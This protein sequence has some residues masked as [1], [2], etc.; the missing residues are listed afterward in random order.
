[1]NGYLYSRRFTG[2]FLRRSRLSRLA[3]F[4][5]LF[6][7]ALWMTAASTAFAQV[8]TCNSLT[9]YGA[10]AASG[11]CKSLSPTSQTHWVCELAAG[12]PDIHLTF[13]AATALHLTVRIPGTSGP[14][15]EGNSYLAGTF[16][17]K[18]SIQAGQPATICNVKVQ[19]WVTR[20]NAVAPIPPQG[21]QCK[22]GF[23]E[24]ERLGRI[25]ASV[26]NGYQQKCTDNRCQ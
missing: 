12:N 6:T 26:S 22:A 11:L 25:T 17:G 24:A 8:N 2:S 10:A 14:T 16:P 15:C 5:T 21:A 9:L 20:L 3:R 4:G 23:Q 13:N 1:M 18:F 19:D 7:A